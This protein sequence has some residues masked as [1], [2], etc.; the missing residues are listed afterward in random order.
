MENMLKWCIKIRTTPSIR[1]KTGGNLLSG[2]GI[3]VLVRALSYKYHLRIATT[4]Q[5]RPPFWS[6]N[7]ILFNMEVPLN[8]DHMAATATNLGSLRWSFPKGIKTSATKTYYP[9]N[10]ELYN[11]SCLIE[12]LINIIANFQWSH[13]PFFLMVIKQKSLVVVTIRLMSSLLV[14]PKVIT[15]SGS[16]CIWIKHQVLNCCTFSG[17]NL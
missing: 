7:L 17:K 13:S 6:P 1:L 15:L 2:V 3:K 9:C 5:Q 8:N 16:N 4:C 14:R 10:A 11:E 12:S